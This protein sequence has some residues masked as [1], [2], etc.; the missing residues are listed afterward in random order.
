MFLDYDGTLTPIVARPDLAVLSEEMR[1]VIGE[2]SRR[3]PVAILSG[4]RR[5]EVEAMVKIPDLYFA[6]SHGFDIRGPGITMTPEE[7][8]PFVPLLARA[9]RTLK[10]S[11]QG[12]CGSLVE[13]KKFAIAVHYR[14]VDP[15][16]VPRMESM[17]DK[18]V[19]AEPLFRKTGGKKIFEIRPNLPWDKGKALLYLLKILKLDHPKVL[20]IYLGDDETDEDAFR[21]LVGRGLGI[22]VGR[23]NQKTEASY[24][25]AN[26]PEVK[27][28][29]QYLLKGLSKDRE[30]SA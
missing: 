5:E 4:R 30:G 17:V 18:I 21:V 1:Q 16:E 23:E 6:G 20:P 12:I 10:Q 25:L 22:R 8:L 13:D 7:V 14:L 9:Y 24:S 26:V 15:Q 27:I 3:C 11:T 28:F 19:G 29:L 2:L